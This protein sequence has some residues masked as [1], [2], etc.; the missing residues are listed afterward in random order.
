MDES[1]N[2]LKLLAA[3]ALLGIPLAACEEATPPPPV[4]SIVGTVSIEGTGIDGVSVNLSNGNSTT[5]AGGGSYR[6]DNVEGGAYTVTISGFP[7][8]ATF[9][10]TSAA[11]TISSAGQSV[12]VNFSGAYIRTASVMGTVTV[13][14]V[15]LPGVTVTLSGVSGAMATTDNSGQYAFTGLRMGS[16]S[17]EISG[18]DNDEIGF[19]NTAA[20][21]SVGVG[22]SKI[23]SFDGTYLRTAGIMGR[24]SVEGD[25][26]EGV[27]VSLAG[28]PDNAD[29]TTMTDAAG[30]YSFAKLRAG[31]YAVGISGYD[32]D[33][34]EFEVTSQNVTVALG[35]TANVPFEGVLLRTSGISGR[36][37]VEGIGL[38]DI[39]VTLSMADAED[40]TAMT[41]VG[42]LY[43]FAGLAAGDYT[44]AIAVESDAYVFDSMSM[45]VTVGDDETAIV[46]FEGMH[47]R[48]ASVTVQLFI[49]ELMKNDMHDEGEMPFP[50]PEML[51]MVAELGLPLALPVTL[52]GPGVHDVQQGTVTPTGA[53]T[54]AGLMAG[55]YQVIVTDIPAETLAA[56]PPALG[57]V[58]QDYAYGGP[59]TGYA[60]D[61]G[62]GEQA[63]QGAPI[64]ITHTTVHFGVTLKAGEMRGMPLAGAAVALY[65]DAM[66]ETKVGEGMTE[67]DEATGHAAASIRI[68]R[69]GTS[70]NMVHAGVAAEG[71]HVAD[72]M[73]AVPWDPQKTYTMGANDNDIVNLNVD[74]TFSG[75]TVDRGDYGGGDALAGW[76]V[77]VM[78]G[79]STLAGD[80]VPAML[81][82]DGM[83]A[84]KMSVE[85]VPAM[86]TFSVDTIQDNKLDGGENFDAT[87]ATYTHTGLTLTG[88]TDAGAI[89]VTYTTQTLKVY[90]HHE[91][92]QVHGYTGNIL[93]GDYRSSAGI[94]VGIRHID[95]SGR[96]RAFPSAAGI[97]TPRNNGDKG[98][99]TFSNVP[100]DAKVIVQAKKAA[101]AGNIML[102]DPDELA[103]YTDMDANGITGGAFGDQ[104]GS[105]HTV[106]LC[107]LMATDPTGQDHGECG[108]FAWVNTYGVSG[109]VW[110]RQ[111][112]KGATS[113][114]DDAFT[115]KDPVFVPGISVALDPVDGK[116]LAGDSK[117]ATTTKDPVRTAG[118]TSKGTEVLDERVQF[119]FGQMAAGVY[120]L[121][122]SDGWRARMGAKGAET[123]LG[124]SLDP[125]A[126]DL[127]IDVTPATTIVYG[128][129][130]DSE[131]FPVDSATVSVNGVE[132]TT[133]IHGRYIAEGIAPQTRRINNVWYR[134]MIFVETGETGNKATREI[135]SFAANS[136]S[137]Q[138][139]ALTGVGKTASISGTVTASGSGAPVAGAEILVDGEAPLNKA[140]RGVNAGKLVTGAD[141]TYTA[142]I[143]AKALG[144]TA[145]VTVSKAGMSFVP[146]ALD[147][148]AHEG[149]EISGIDFAGFLH[150]TIRGRVKGPDGN[151]MGG[152][153]VTATN[154]GSGEVFEMVTSTG[155][156]R[157]TFALS[158]PFG[159]YN[160]EA[161][162][163]GYSFS[164]PNNN[165]TV[166]VAPGQQLNF[167]D[168][169]ATALPPANN[170]PR[171][172][173]GA[174]FDAAEGQMAIGTVT[175]V[176]SD[177]EDDVTGYAITGGADMGMLSINATSGV[178]TFDAAPDFETPGDAD[179]DNSYEVTV[180]ATSGVANRVLT[181]TQDIS[182]NV[183]DVDESLP[184]V[185]L[186]LT[187]AS[188]TENGG[189]SRISATVD[190]ASAEAFDVT[191]SAAAVAPAVAGDFIL[192]N[193]M[194]LSF[195]AN[196]ASS[197]GAVSIT[198][199]NND[200][201]AADKT[202][203]VSGSVSSTDV[204][205]PAD[206]TLTIE[207]DDDKP[208]AE[209][210]L[211]A[212]SLSGV[213]AAA[214]GFDPATTTYAVSV[215]NEIAET[216]VDA[217]A[218][219]G[220]TV[221]AILPTD[222]DDMTAGHQVALAVGDT[223]ITVV[224]TA[225]GGKRADYVITVTRM[226]SSDASLSSVTVNGTDVPVGTDG[227]YAHD[228]GNDVTEAT[229][230]AVAMAADLGAS[231]SYNPSD[232]DDSDGSTI[233]LDVGANMVTVTV[234]A[235]NGS[236]MDHMVTVN[237]AASSDASL[238]MFTV[239]TTNVMAD[240]TDGTYTHTVASTVAQVTVSATAGHAEG[241][242]AITSPADADDM[243]EGHQVDLEPGDNTI[244][245]TV[246]AEDGT[247]EAMYE[248]TVTRTIEAGILV[249]MDEIELGE[250]EMA[251]YMVSLATR[252]DADVV[253]T[254]APGGGLSV[255]RTTLNFA[256]ENWNVMQDV[257]VTADENNGDFAD[258]EGLIVGH[259]SVEGAA[260]GDGDDYDI[261]TAVNVSVDVTNDD[262]ENA[263]VTVTPTTLTAVEGGDG[264]TFEVTLGAEPLS[265]V[266]VT[267][268][269]PEGREGDLT[270]SDASLTFT[271]DNFAT[272]QEVT[273]TATDDDVDADKADVVLAIAANGGG[274]SDI[275]G[276]A[277]D[278]VTVAITDD[279]EAAVMVTGLAG[280]QVREGGS[281]DY[282]VELATQPEGS[283]SILVSA[284]G[285]HNTTFTF[286]ET[287]WNMAQS[288]T[289]TVP[290][291]DNETDETVTLAFTVGGY[292]ALA[293]NPSFSVRDNDGAAGGVI[294]S[295]TQL[296][297]AA[298]G[299]G[300]YMLSLT[301]A[302]ATGESLT[303]TVASAGQIGINPLTVT[304]DTGNWNAGVRV[305]LSP[306][307][308]ATGSITVTNTA[309]ASTGGADADAK[310]RTAPTVAD[311]TVTIP[312]S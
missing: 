212:L 135:I 172:T 312:A 253:V 184:R 27:T 26:L 271:T 295:H 114:N 200:D 9:D 116:N 299:T 29:M 71:Y 209:A 153:S 142:T 229:V 130:R 23:V 22:E 50:T 219:E 76:A 79:D 118:E 222:A 183:T 66:G 175:A 131:E 21:V 72:G 293:T 189:V 56:L 109:L 161:S 30:Q 159:T 297:I 120:K 193:N 101:D 310:Y 201:Y 194:T 47:A 247:T 301:Q 133:D 231:V 43:A 185:T 121:S 284:T 93:D 208:P 81:D 65:S 16:Y 256:P 106:S 80:D 62:V 276:D 95:D 307:A 273:V 99:W 141:G 68:A 5:T 177:P 224:V 36:V 269:V 110:K 150:A 132:A 202:V 125:L 206:V 117:S 17:V 277:A 151:A 149:A 112:V 179:G 251:T 145:K 104:G 255:N 42:G 281:L 233:A 82:D 165:Q 296:S 218:S 290:E 103:A 244:M 191:V 136:P 28:G 265:D 92:D 288:R 52:A 40:M 285:V 15:G 89:E 274:Y 111:V 169:Q 10:A 41:D 268:G 64:D 294:V 205:A 242:A 245:A 240:E 237:R 241:T 7:S 261:T 24:V 303:V 49:D 33:D 170:P 227:S 54:F 249:S 260:A 148:P 308:Q 51:A 53:V 88:T 69:A 73:T 248:L 298:G 254:I 155:N 18:F 61:L 250:G 187:P 291:D 44:V 192:S 63:M 234:T 166:S 216:T 115:I 203:T 171:F 243:A 302:P 311:V 197:T 37:S 134:N 70:G 282:Q 167:G 60:I 90:V 100:A 190:K 225:P 164:Y 13:E 258:A 238:A 173:S 152:V 188:I 246:T 57:A 59:A 6:F 127:A 75:A 160:I 215:A 232:G 280:R 126:S 48:T 162:A 58:L 137:R 252:P 86:F 304:F 168:I 292:A 289:I 108:S 235:A 226:E 123:L 20:S 102:L 217:T 309:A 143:A 97:S 122:V 207:E 176:D 85:S 199:V 45:D 94:D 144:Q 267:I 119:N 129:V 195:A 182:V 147:A 14:N 279:D 39:T 158:V 74:V 266:T 178:L 286:D 283:V 19:S 32:T 287:N 257:E 270:V 12:T 4:G 186:V 8:D 236:T 174:S 55:Q 262:A 91:R 154:T 223:E 228:V 3:V 67:V 196:A 25:G 78:M 35:E 210:T 77:S 139:I 275:V 211:S 278:D 124:G 84:F 46:N 11:A 220:A 204:T 163:D 263:A 105:S 146:A 180:E 34:F 96:S 264:V 140:T 83:A 239:G 2:R 31:D 181:E 305:D 38:E 230:V 214:L 300:Q 306:L 87:N 128:Y 272:A 157:G 138:D 156:A 107:P 213:D 98:V 259:T 198:A 221:A 113:A 1:M